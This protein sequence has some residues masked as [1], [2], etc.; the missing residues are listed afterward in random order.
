VTPD[1]LEAVRRVVAEAVTEALASAA[2][3]RPPA[4]SRAGLLTLEQASAL[5]A[6]TSI[7]TIRGWIWRGK[8]RAYKPGKHPLVRESELLA[9]VEANESRAKRVARRRASKGE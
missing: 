8:L 7:E 3:A 9:F 1:E 6:G 2:P 4:K 5:L